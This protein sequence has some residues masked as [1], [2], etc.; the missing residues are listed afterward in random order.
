MDGPK[1]H[2]YALFRRGLAASTSALTLRGP[3]QSI[4]DDWESPRPSIGSEYDSKT[5]FVAVAAPT[6]EKPDIPSTQGYP[7]VKHSSGITLLLSGHKAGTSC[8]V[9]HSGSL[10]SGMVVLSKP[11]SVISLEVKVRHIQLPCHFFCHVKL[12]FRISW[13]ALPLFEKSKEVAGVA[14][15][16]IRTS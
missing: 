6:L 15:S 4:F 11:S 10:I 8:P 2:P 16:F 9:Y 1:N 3:R 13:K 12:T 14:S 7:Y 5:E